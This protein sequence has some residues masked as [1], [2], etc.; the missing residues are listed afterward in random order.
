M[1]RPNRSGRVAAHLSDP[2]LRTGYLLVVGSGTTAALGLVFWVVAARLFSPHLIGLNS[3]MI[4]AALFIANACQLGLPAVL[5]R[6]VPRAGSHTQWLVVRSYLIMFG[7]SLA[8]GALAALTTP[9]WFRPL[10]FMAHEPG[11]VVGFALS[12][13]FY[14]IFQG[15][16]SLLTAIGVPHW[17]PI[18]NTLFSLAKLL[19]LF[20][21]A[22]T[23]S[24]AGPFVAWNVPAAVGAVVITWMLFRRIR[25]RRARPATASQFSPRRFMEM[26]AANQIALI[27]TYVVTL[28]MPAV[29]AAATSA[30]QAAYFFVPW[31]IANGVMYV[32]INTA[33][34][35]TVQSSLHPGELPSLT[36]RTVVQTMRLMLPIVLITAAIAPL[37]LHIYGSAYAQHGTWLLRLVLLG[38]LPNAI[39]VIGEALLRIQHRPVQLVLVQGGQSIAFLLLSVT[40]IA[41]MGINGVGVAFVIVQVGGAAW[42]LASV[43]HP[44]AGRQA[45]GN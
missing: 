11:W 8:I 24:L 42:L 35:L 1:L 20:A 34:G 41:Y 32:A 25:S 19:L 5:L 33:T 13:A 29:V 14:A 43:L 16:D 45:A 12:C 26:A 10:S 7:T 28:L 39:Y 37:L 18:E 30:T 17:V 44:T 2:L 31:S 40:L 15:Q 22:A 4:S 27:C 3:V 23:F 38:S 6:D 21:I 36:R 9:L